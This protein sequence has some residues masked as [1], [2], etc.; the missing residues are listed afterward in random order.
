MILDQIHPRAS[1]PSSLNDSSE[2]ISAPE[3]GPLAP[4]PKNIKD[5]EKSILLFWL[6][7]HLFPSKEGSL[8]GSIY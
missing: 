8:V 2:I 7:Y 4:N 6:K 5:K 3:F 1:E